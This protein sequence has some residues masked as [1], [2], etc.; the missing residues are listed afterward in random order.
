VQGWRT[1]WFQVG[2]PRAR[3]RFGGRSRKQN[4]P[5]LLIPP[6][7]PHDIGTFSR[8][9]RAAEIIRLGERTAEEALSQMPLDLEPEPQMKLAAEPTA[10]R[11]VAPR[12]VGTDTRTRKGG[13][14]LDVRVSL[15]LGVMLLVAA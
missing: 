6:W 5:D 10:E 1:R 2:A 7:L 3:R 11:A 9:T 8:L 15:A 13:C 12:T 14:A 4:P